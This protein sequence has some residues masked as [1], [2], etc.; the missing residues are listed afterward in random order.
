MLQKLGS[1]Y[2]DRLTDPV[3]TARA[4]KRVL[5]LSPGHAKALRV[6]RDAYLSSGDFANLEGLYASQNDWDSAGRRA[7]DGVG[8][9]GRS[10]AEGGSRATRGEGLRGASQRARAS[11]PRLRTNPLGA[12]GRR[13]RRARACA[14]L[15]AG[16]EVG[17]V[18]P[19]VRDPAVARGYDRGSRRSLSQAGGRRRAAIA[20]QGGGDHLRAEGVRTLT[21]RRRRARFLGAN[22]AAMPARGTR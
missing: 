21:E 14:D 1:V 16:R 2:A 5:E 22:R 18:A 13:S 4:W 11:L 15:R 7:V 19:A 10:D 9:S 12:A 3:G 20:R 17:Q 6:L 8:E